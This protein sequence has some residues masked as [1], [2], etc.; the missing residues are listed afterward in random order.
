MTKEQGLLVQPTAGQDILKKRLE[1]GDIEEEGLL[2]TK[3]GYNK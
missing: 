1:R 2:Y 3:R